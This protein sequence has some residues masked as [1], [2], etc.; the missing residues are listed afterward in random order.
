MFGYFPSCKLYPWILQGSWPHPFGEAQD[1]TSSSVDDLL[2]SSTPWDNLQKE[3]SLPS[4][5]LG[6]KATQGWCL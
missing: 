1:P 2:K 4:V 3:V 6:K 5:L